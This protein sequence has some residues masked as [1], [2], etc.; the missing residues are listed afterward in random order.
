[1]TDWEDQYRRSETPWDKG[2][3]H[4]ELVDFLSRQ[5]LS[6]RILVPGC[7]FGYDVAAI[8]AAG[9]VDDVV[10]LD[11]APSAVAETSR[12]LA[13]VPNVHILQGDLFALPR[14]HRG[15]YD[16]VFEH[17]CFC[18]IDPSR[19]NAYVQS[20]AD[21][22]RPGAHLLAIFYLRP[23]EDGEDPRKGPPFG[24]TEAELDARFAPRFEIVRTAPVTATYPGREGREQL[25][26]LRKT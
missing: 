13:D 6:G 8:A 21:T 10:G 5:P 17:T 24:V 23:W 25:R 1:M 16:W 11:I 15:A 2:G 22:L 20:V 18:A 12:R 14:E 26:L 7:G 3:P 4:P 9:A 19:R